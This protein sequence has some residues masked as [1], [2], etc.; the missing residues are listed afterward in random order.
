MAKEK[1]EKNPKAVG[2]GRLMAWQLREVSAGIALMAIGYIT[3][4]C[5]D[6]LGMAPALVGT[7]LL[8]SKILDGFTEKSSLCPSRLL[9]Q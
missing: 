2:F 8:V 5:T 4:Y 3:L 6:T 9:K 7:L 1:K